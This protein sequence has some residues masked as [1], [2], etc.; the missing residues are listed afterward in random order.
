VAELLLRDGHQGKSGKKKRKKDTLKR[1]SEIMTPLEKLVLAL[2][3]TETKKPSETV[4]NVSADINVRHTEHGVGEAAKELIKKELV[5]LD[6]Q[7][8]HH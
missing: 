5:T 4:R 8:K 6:D 7:I 1:D 2:S 3:D